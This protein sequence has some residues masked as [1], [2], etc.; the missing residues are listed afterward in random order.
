MYKLVRALRKLS[1]RLR[2]VGALQKQHFKISY[3]EN[4]KP[5]KPVYNWPNNNNNNNKLYLYNTFE[6]R[7][8][9]VLL[10]VK[11]KQETQKTVLQNKHSTVEPNPRKP[12]PR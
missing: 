10:T 3:E 9:K 12:R 1:R 6:D 8:Y 4:S 11:Q 2:A 7:V 5:V